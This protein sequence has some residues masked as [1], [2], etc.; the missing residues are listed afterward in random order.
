VYEAEIGKRIADFGALV[1]S[2]AADDAIGQAE[3]DEAILELAHL[4]RGAH[5]NC[6]LVEAMF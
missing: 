6:D 1:K 4:E 3:G 5:E 2:R